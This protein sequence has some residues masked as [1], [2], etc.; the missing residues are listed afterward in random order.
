[1]IRETLSAFGLEYCQSSRLLPMQRTTVLATSDVQLH[2]KRWEQTA[3]RNSLVAL[4]AMIL[5][6]RG[7][8][9]EEFEGF[10]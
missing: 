9:I 4:A 1:M 2:C 6:D 5:S 8:S 3:L 10:A 7:A